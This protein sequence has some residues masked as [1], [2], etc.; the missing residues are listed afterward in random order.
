M[1]RIVF[2]LLGV[3]GLSCILVV[4]S[5]EPNNFGLSLGASATG[6]CAYGACGWLLAPYHGDVPTL[7]LPA[8][9]QQAESLLL[10][11]VLLFVILRMVDLLNQH[12][13]YTRGPRSTLTG[14]IDEKR[15]F[16]VRRGLAAHQ[17]RNKL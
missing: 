5:W 17:A 16:Y 13:A 9:L 4:T 14:I 6:P 12:L 1:Q 7:S 8:W 15:V 2:K 10:L 3:L 11:T